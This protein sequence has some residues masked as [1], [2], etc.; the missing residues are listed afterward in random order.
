MM[1]IVFILCETLA[2]NSC[3]ERVHDFVPALPIPCIYAAGPELALISPEGWGV[4]SWRCE[5]VS[6]M[7]ENS[8]ARPRKSDLP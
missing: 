3:E 4:D 6:Q 5:E 2:A 8:G 1:R 7:A